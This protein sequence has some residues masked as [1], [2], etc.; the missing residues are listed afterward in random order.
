MRIDHL[1]PL[2]LLTQ[3][4]PEYVLQELAFV[5]ESSVGKSHIRLTCPD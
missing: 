4:S 3:R 1:K 2:N 5:L